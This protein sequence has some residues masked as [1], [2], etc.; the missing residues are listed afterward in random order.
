MAAVAAEDPQTEAAVIAR[1]GTALAT[2]TDF[3]TRSGAVRVVAVLDAG[4]GRAAALVEAEPDG[5]ATVE[6]GDAVYDVT[7][8]ALGG[9]QPL[10]L[11]LARP[12]PPSAWQVDPETGEVVAPPGAVAGMAAGLLALAAALGGRSVATADFRTRDGT[13][14]TIAARVGEPLIL[15]VG[16]QQFE[17]PIHR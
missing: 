16:D 7:A 14:V 17:L 2:V 15:A 8:D 6:A 11:E 5:T 9:V 1:H 10:A 3:A 13:E 12:L 4:D